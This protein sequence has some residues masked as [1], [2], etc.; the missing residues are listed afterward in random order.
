VTT[1]RFFRVIAHASTGEEP[2]I[3]RRPRRQVGR[4]QPEGP[5]TGPAT[6]LLIDACEPRQW[7]ALF[8]PRWA[9]LFAQLLA[10]SLDRQLAQG[11]SPESSRLLATRVQMIVSPAARYALAQSC[12]NVLVQARRP[13]VMRNPRAPLN[14]DCI[15]ACETQIREMINALL[16][17]L[18]TPA[19]GTAMVSQLLSDGSGPLY[20][21]H[22]SADLGI[23]VAKAVAQLDP[24]VCL[25][26]SA[27]IR[28]FGRPQDE[29]QGG[30]R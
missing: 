30:A 26:P 6:L 29:A 22:H 23:A 27:Q 28:A 21:R 10:S 5:G 14:R 24:S 8:N 3:D 17:P 20:N 18:A 1:A 16:A 13:S 11:C 4:V 25:V 9:R 2:R 19:R 7:I 12:D 15:L